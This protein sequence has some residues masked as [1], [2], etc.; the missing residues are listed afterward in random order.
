VS[1]SVVVVAVVAV[2]AAVVVVI[3]AVVV[4]VVVGVAGSTITAVLRGRKKTTKGFVWRL[5]N[6]NNSNKNSNKNSN[7]NNNSATAIAAVAVRKR[8]TANRK[9]VDVVVVDVV[10]DVGALV[11][12]VWG[13][14]II[15][16]IRNSKSQTQTRNVCDECAVVYEVE[17]LDWQMSGSS[18]PIAF[19][20]PSSVDLIAKAGVC[21]YVCVCVCVCVVVDE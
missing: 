11:R 16:N 7:N 19:L 17:L 14:G 10:D 18:L 2:V 13:Q 15:R 12:T 4:V 9:A 8:T 3:V 5:S 1:V 20:Q 21:V 6:N